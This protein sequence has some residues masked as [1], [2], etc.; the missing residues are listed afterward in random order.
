MVGMNGRMTRREM[1]M[2]GV[3]VTKWGCARTRVTWQRGNMADG[4]VVVRVRRGRLSAGH[5]ALVGCGGRSADKA[6]QV[7]WLVR[8]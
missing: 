6:R 4:D 3:G 1:G 5:N 7:R 8:R 2:A